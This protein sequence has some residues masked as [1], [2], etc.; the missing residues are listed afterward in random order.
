[1]GCFSTWI[2][3]YCYNCTIEICSLMNVTIFEPKIN[4]AQFIFFLK[5]KI[6]VLELD[7]YVVWLIVF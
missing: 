5:L 6:L 3:K 4:V 7:L 2:E 1:M